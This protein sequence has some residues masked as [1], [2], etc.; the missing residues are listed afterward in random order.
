[1]FQKVKIAKDPQTR[2]QPRILAVRDLGSAAL[3]CGPFFKSQDVKGS[4]SAALSFMD[5][6]AVGLSGKPPYVR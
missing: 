5:S 6:R 1:M 2:R 4:G 3:I